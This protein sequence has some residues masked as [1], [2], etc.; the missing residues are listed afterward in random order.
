LFSV[1]KGEI[2]VFTKHFIENINFKNPDDTMVQMFENQK[3][4]D[5]FINQSN[6]KEENL[7]NQ[8]DIDKS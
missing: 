3:I 8:S 7:S 5:S 4:S 1:V 6:E 2:E